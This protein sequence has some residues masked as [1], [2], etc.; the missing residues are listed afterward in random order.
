MELSKHE[1]AMLKCETKPPVSRGTVCATCGEEQLLEGTVIEN[2]TAYADYH[3]G[4]G[5]HNVRRFAL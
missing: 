5:G 4:H 2:D 1:E 3:C